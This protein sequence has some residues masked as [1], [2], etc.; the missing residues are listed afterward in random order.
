HSYNDDEEVYVPQHRNANV[1]VVQAGEV[2]RKLRVSWSQ[3]VVERA[4]A[5]ADDTKGEDCATLTHQ[6]PPFKPVEIKA[7]PYPLPRLT[8]RARPQP[9]SQPDQT[10]HL[11]LDITAGPSTMCRVINLLHEEEKAGV[12]QGTAVQAASAALSGCQRCAAS[13]PARSPDTAAW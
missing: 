2:A 9:H 1:S 10:L 4:G 11:R 3:K 13:C 7:D 6:A 5:P 8:P 12:K